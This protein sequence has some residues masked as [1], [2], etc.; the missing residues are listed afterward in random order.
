MDEK[1]SLHSSVLPSKK[2]Y[3]SNPY[4]GIAFGVLLIPLNTYWIAQLE[5]VRYT[6]PTLVVPFFNVI[7]ILLFFTVFNQVVVKIWRRPLLSQLDLITIY[8]ML[9]VSSAIVSIDFLQVLVSNMG[10]AFY[11]ATPENEWKTLFCDSLP[12]WLVVSDS[13]ALEGYYKGSTTLYSP[14]HLNPWIVPILIW[15]GFILVLLL[16]MLCFCRIVRWQ[17]IEKEK[18]T[19]PIIHLPLEISAG[20]PFFFRNKLMWIGLLLAALISLNNGLH[21]FFPALPDFPVKRRTISRLFNE[22][23]WNFMGSVKLSFYPFV[24][25]VSFLIP[26]DLLFSCWVFYWLYKVERLLIGLIGW[27]GLNR[28][29]YQSEQAFGAVVSL[30]FFLLWIGKAQLRDVVLTARQKEGSNPPSERVAVFGLIA[31]F[32]FLLLVST[33][34]GMSIAV[35]PV[36]F[37]F[38]FLISFF[39]TRMRAELGLCVHGLGGLEPRRI[40]LAGIGTKAFSKETLVAFSLYGFFNRVYR[41][42]PMPHLLE[43]FKMS[44]MVGSPARWLT[45][46]VLLSVLVSSVVAFWVYL[47]LYYRFGASSGYFGIWTLGFGRE[48]FTRLQ[49]WIHFPTETDHAGLSFMGIGFLIASMLTFLRMR[50]LWFPLHPLGYAMAGDWGMSNLWSC[51]FTS[52][53]IKWTIFK[54]GGLR[55]YRN[56]VPFFLGMALG[57]LTVGS[58]WSL[59]GVFMDETIYQPFP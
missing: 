14:H 36:F 22:S 58:L 59:I 24:I 50:F 37:G 10:H 25:G 34:V 35:V 57:D 20:K 39:I 12:S 16:M 21:F 51:F 56:A 48:T 18:L 28:F 23:P 7:F 32:L 6:H 41:N 52:F 19:Y 4:I 42:H 27:Q 49:N 31:G 26:L 44:V 2:D 8:L 55:S 9:S 46:A 54:Y 17:W 5:V 45:W 47:D 30:T 53:L 13:G 43:G 3:P 33:R 1:T 11:F 40:I 38:Y 15:T 29:P